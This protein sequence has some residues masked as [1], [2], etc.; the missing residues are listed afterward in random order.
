MPSVRFLGML[1]VLVSVVGC[2]TEVQR[3]P[4]EPATKPQAQEQ[5]PTKKDAFPT[6]TYRPG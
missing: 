4:V 3:E 1:L 5:S 6:F 2:A